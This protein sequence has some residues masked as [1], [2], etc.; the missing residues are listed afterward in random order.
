MRRDRWSM[1][2]WHWIRD[3]QRDKDARRYPG[4]G[5]GAMATRRTAAQPSGSAPCSP[6]ASA[7]K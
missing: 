5:A 3:A 1:E 6:A 4:T 7:S 2:G